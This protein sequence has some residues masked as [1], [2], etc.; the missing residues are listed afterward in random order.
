MPAASP[1]LF[2]R[3]MA[4][5]LRAAA[6]ALGAPKIAIEPFSRCAALASSAVI[7][8]RDGGANQRQRFGASA[9]NVLASERIS[10]SFP[11]V[12]RRRCV[13][14]SSRSAQRRR[15][16]LARRGAVAMGS[17]GGVTQPRLA[18]SPRRARRR[19]DCGIR[20]IRRPNTACP[21]RPASP[22][23]IHACF[24]ETDFVFFGG[25]AGDADDDLVFSGGRFLPAN[26]AVACRPVMRGISSSISTTSKVLLLRV[27]R[28]L[29]RPSATASAMCR[30]F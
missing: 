21:F 27:P 20:R 14:T 25:V 12:V 29:A 3:P 6:T 10:L 8:F 15:C 30:A 9:R 22:I 16:R 18:R 7:F 5:R 17:A 13:S 28:E 19:R 4:S 2:A 11:P 23:R 1:R 24:T 26:R